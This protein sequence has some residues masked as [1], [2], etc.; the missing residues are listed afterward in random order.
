MTETITVYT[1]DDYHE[2]LKFWD[3]YTDHLMN[4]DHVMRRGR[5][6]A[7]LEQDLMQ[8]GCTL[9]SVTVAKQSAKYYKQQRLE[10]ENKEGYTE[11]MLRHG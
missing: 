4:R 7:M 2:P 5:W 8:Y 10:F 11:F 1:H 6:W 9:H 3:N